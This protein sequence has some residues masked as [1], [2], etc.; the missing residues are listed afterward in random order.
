M[1]NATDSP[2]AEQMAG[3]GELLMSDA[4]RKVFAVFAALEAHPELDERLRNPTSTKGCNLPLESGGSV[5]VSIYEAAY[6]V[7]LWDS[8]MRRR[9]LL[10]ADVRRMLWPER[11][12]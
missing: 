8:G 3:L 10:G 4:M 6:F 2:F 7:G 9:H 5:R 1:T 12:A 11:K